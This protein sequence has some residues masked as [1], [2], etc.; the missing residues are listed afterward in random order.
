M[1]GIFQSCISR[2]YWMISP[3]KPISHVANTF[4]LSLSKL[5]TLIAKLAVNAVRNSMMT[6]TRWYALIHRYQYTF[7]IATNKLINTKLDRIFLYIYLILRNI[8]NS[9]I[10]SAIG[11]IFSIYANSAQII[12]ILWVMA[13]IN[14]HFLLL[15][16]Y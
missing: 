6:F 14:A 11:S 3:T 15:N 2:N 8:M 9:R 1:Q 13:V 12:M 10:C 5:P 16:V 4:S 7:P